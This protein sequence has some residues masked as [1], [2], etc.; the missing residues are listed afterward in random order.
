MSKMEDGGN[1]AFR[2][3]LGHNVADFRRSG[4]R[5]RADL[6]WHDA[7]QRPISPANFWLAWEKCNH[8]APSLRFQSPRE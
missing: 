7:A 1:M 8:L 5:I 4:I 6:S 3:Y 2:P